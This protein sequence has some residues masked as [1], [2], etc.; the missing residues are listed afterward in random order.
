MGKG[1]KTPEKTPEKTRLRQRPRRPRRRAKARPGT[2][3]DK[4][5]LQIK[6]RPAE[7]AAVDRAAESA[8]L[9][10]ATWARQTLLRGA[11]L[12]SPNNAS[13]DPGSPGARRSGKRD[14]RRG[15]KLPKNDEHERARRG[16]RR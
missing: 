3:Q 10:R 16:R 8:W 5:I 14:R 11:G 7:K 12:G 13:G 9:P 6:L 15:D 2:T 1:A 4:H